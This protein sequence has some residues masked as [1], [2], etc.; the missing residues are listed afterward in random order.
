MGFVDRIPDVDEGLLWGCKFVTAPQT[1]PASK[2]FMASMFCL[3]EVP[4]HLCPG[5]D[6]L[7]FAPV[8]GELS[9][10]T[11]QFAVNGIDDESFPFFTD[12]RPGTGKISK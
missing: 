8:T 5:P 4:A 3:V 10:R 11:S 7:D 6:V 2:L 9:F 1:F 12:T